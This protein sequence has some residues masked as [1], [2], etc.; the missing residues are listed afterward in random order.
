MPEVSVI[1]P[2]YGPH[3]G[4]SVLPT[5]A[6]AWLMQDVS[7]EVIVATPGP[8]HRGHDARRRRR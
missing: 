7:C 6:C 2:L 5:V 1:I 8:A 3:R 4:R